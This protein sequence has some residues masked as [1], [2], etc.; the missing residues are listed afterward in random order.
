MCSRIT[1]AFCLDELQPALLPLGPRG[2]AALD[3]AGERRRQRALL[4]RYPDARVHDRE[5]DDALAQIEQVTQEAKHYLAAL[6]IDRQRLDEELEFY[7]GDRTKAPTALRE[8]FEEN[9]VS[10]RAQNK[11]IQSMDE[12]RQRLALRFANERAQL[13]PLWQTVAAKR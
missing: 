5:R 11:F 1:P 4:V 3:R 10:V 12:D 9:E 8:R 7:R 2:L 13:E 6:K